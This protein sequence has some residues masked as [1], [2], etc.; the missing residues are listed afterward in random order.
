MRISPSAA[1]WT[2]DILIVGDRHWNCAELAE[3]IVSRL[4]VR[5]GLDVTIIHGGEPGVD[6]AIDQACTNLG[7][8]HETRL[9]SWHQTGLPTI[10][11]KNRELIKAAP[12]LCVAIR[13]R[14][15]DSKRT[16]DCVLQALQAGIATFLIADERA[17][18]R[19]LQA[20]DP[21]LG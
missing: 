10:A 18:P 8:Q 2:C 15:S 5:Y 13:Q 7:I 21:G 11:T 6:H 17:I 12:N 14:I 4:L 16:R 20:R 9:P 1:I 19:Q 3:Q